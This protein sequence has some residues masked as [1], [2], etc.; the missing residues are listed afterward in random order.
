MDQIG[1]YRVLG[2]IGHGAMG[3]VF[4]AHDAVLNRFVAIKTIAADLKS[5][6]TLRKR[7]EREAQSA[8]RLNHPNVVTV[9]DF[10][11]EQDKVYMAMELL[12]GHDLKQAIASR[13]LPDLLGRLSIMEQI[14]DGLAFA[15]AA[16]IIHRDLKPA[17]IHLQPNGQ[18]KIMD[19][20]LA[21]LSGS[22]MTRTGM[23]MGTPH[24]MSPEQVRG[25]RADA[26][27]DIFA[28]GCVFYEMLTYT[29]PF[30]ADSMHAVLFKVMQEEP[31]SL[32]DVAPET[33]AVLVEILERCLLKD[34]EERFQNAGEL[35]DAMRA[36]RQAVLAGR[37]DETLATLLRLP[38][39][40]P[41]EGSRSASGSA[42]TARLASGPQRSSPRSRS[43]APCTPCAARRRRRP[44]R[45]PRARPRWI[46][47]RRR[48]W[49]R[50]WSWRAR[51]ST[52]AT[53]SRPRAS[54]SAR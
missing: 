3:E 35:R 13:T 27:S 24:Y 14:C 15:H 11:E 34:P 50:R 21:R 41:R 9:Y 30:D 8:A 51:S 37:G 29:K 31:P 32:A 12:E 16:E 26:R 23:V 45:S 1:K 5:D 10:G 42:P 22:E 54:P 19:F 7:F 2:R 18:V 46:A 52:P 44:R 33:P 17:N 28:L 43:R 36:A 49:A 6:D 48:W 39:R 40:D 4:K 53:S 47:W 20:G 38:P 25:E